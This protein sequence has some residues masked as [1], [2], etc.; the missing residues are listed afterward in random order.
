M[1]TVRARFAHANFAPHT[2]P[3]FQNVVLPAVWPVLKRAG[4]A[5]IKRL[6]RSV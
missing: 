1:R 2:S 6:K 4:T 5:R 3:S